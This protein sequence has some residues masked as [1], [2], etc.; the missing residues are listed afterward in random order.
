MP[1]GLFAVYQVESQLLPITYAKC[2]AKAGH[3]PGFVDV[4]VKDDGREIVHAAGRINA[5]VVICV[6]FY[7]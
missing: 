3:R 5:L 1:K 7:A 6:V 4:A 2:R